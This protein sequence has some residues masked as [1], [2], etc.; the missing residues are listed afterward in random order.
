MK[1]LDEKIAA[2]QQAEAECAR[3]RSDAHEAWQH[4]RDEVQR[5]AT[6]VRIVVSGVALGFA[7][8]LATSGA[9]AAANGKLVSGPLFS[10]LMDTVVPGLLA[11]ITAAA[12]ASSEVED[13]ADEAVDEAIAEVQ[14]EPVEAAPPAKRK[15]KPRGPRRDRTDA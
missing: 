13:A 14:A 12:T 10:M 6:P 5:T 7:S 15:R 11:G 2:V 8:G 9:A 4:L 3:Q 1:G